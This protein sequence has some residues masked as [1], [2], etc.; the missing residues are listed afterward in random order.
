MSTG[1]NRDRRPCDPP[2]LQE[3]LGCLASYP[4]G[5]L[6]HANE[7]ILISTLHRLCIEHGFG[8]VCQLAIAI[9]AIWWKGKK[10]ERWVE[11]YAEHRKTIRELMG[12][13]TGTTAAID[14]VDL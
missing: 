11:T 9:E 5:T 12:R 2:S 1:Y 8:N 13:R 10:A 3:L 4:E 14:Q 6:G 7:E